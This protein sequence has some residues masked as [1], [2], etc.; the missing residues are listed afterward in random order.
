[1]SSE[2]GLAPAPQAWKPSSSSSSSSQAQPERAESGSLRRAE[3][4]LRPAGPQAYGAPSEEWHGRRRG[5]CVP[6]LSCC[7]RAMRVE[8]PSR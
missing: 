7:P 1:M 3:R 5:A 2:L 8:M 4:G 6:S